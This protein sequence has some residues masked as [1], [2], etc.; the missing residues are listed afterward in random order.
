MSPSIPSKPFQKKENNL[1][2][3]TQPRPY[4]LAETN[5]KEIQQH[6]FDIAV[7]PWGATEAHNYHMPYATDN[8]QV[9]AIAHKAAAK[10]WEKGTKVLILPTIPFGVNTG[11]LDIAYC[12]NMNP[13]T[14]LAI[15]KDV[16]DVVV[17]H[18]ATK[19][20][21]LN[22]HGANNFV[23]MIRELAGL[24]PS[25]FISVINWYQSSKKDDVFIN[26]GDHADEM[27]TSVMMHLH[28]ELLLPLDM[29]G[30]GANKKFTPKGFQEGWAW[31]QRPWT[32]ITNDTGVGDPSKSTPEKGKAFIEKCTDNIA[33]FFCEINQK[34]IETLLK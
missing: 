34:N 30:D 33:E 7:L 14:Q 29:A 26:K 19:F 28:P 22:G 13:S 6:T 21:I 9:D 31:T 32:K 5:W 8:Y 2:M 25:L 18:G 15:L 12:M 20:I 16:C 24:F 17:R 3:T 1:D 23:A 11:Q 4:V 27:E 10:A